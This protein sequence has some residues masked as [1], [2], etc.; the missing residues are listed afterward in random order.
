MLQRFAGK[1]AIVTGGA[2]GIG[3]ASARR[4][5]EEGATVAIADISPEAGE[6][7]VDELRAAGL[8]RVESIATDVA[9]AA[10]VRRSSTP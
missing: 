7:A 4:L 6:R 9:D 8:A 3:L 2:S 10:A 5:L 1:V